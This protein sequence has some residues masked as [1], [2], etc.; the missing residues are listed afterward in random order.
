MATPLA[1]GYARGR[2]HRL[3]GLSFGVAVTI[4][5]TIGSGILKAPG[6]IAA[7]LPTPGLFIGVWVAGGLYAFLGALCIAELGTMIPRAGGQYAFARRALGDYAGLVVGIS[8]WLS[9]CGSAAVV[10]LVI[11]EYL[12]PA[13]AV[14]IAVAITLFFA[15]LQILG[16][17]VS[18]RVQEYTSLLKTLAFALLIAACFAFAGPTSHAAVAPRAGP[19]LISLLIALQAVIFTYDGWTG[20]IYFSEEV[21]DPARDVPRSLFSGVALISAIYLLVNLALVRLGPLAD[22]AGAPLAVGIAAAKIFGAAGEPALRGLTIVSMIAAIHAYHLMA[23]RVLFGLARDGLFFHR[24]MEVNRVGT[25]V[26]ALMV[27]AGVS[28]LFILSGT[29]E[30]VVGVLSFFFVANYSVSFASL[31]ILRRREPAAARPFRTPLYPFLP[32]AT[33]AGSL[34]F[35]GGSIAGDPRGSLLAVGLLATSAAVFLV[36]R[37]R[38]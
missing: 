35:L 9:T 1:A 4:G 12:A 30:Q 31:F 8:D 34:A 33:L 3:L 15:L 29:W 7:L 36:L 18:A 13:H 11:G 5:N 32:A 20:V 23:A 38:Q 26:P 25:P 24:A 19:L 10:A 6:E 17:R 37:R 2:L 27:S 28:I 16:V 14:P 21:T 22:Y